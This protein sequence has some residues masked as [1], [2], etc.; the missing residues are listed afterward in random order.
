MR[1][2]RLSTKRKWSLVWGLIAVLSLGMVSTAVKLNDSVKTEKLTTYDYEIGGLTST[3]SEN[4][5]KGSIRTKDFI[6]TDGLEVAMSKKSEV[7][8][9]LY[10]YDAD[11]SFISMQEAEQTGDYTFPSSGNSAAYVKVVITP[12][13]DTEITLLEKGGYCDDIEVTYDK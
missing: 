7:T 11:E 13:D 9:R 10:F 8:Y 6:P 5:S 12:T 3:G 4:R 2:K 1:M